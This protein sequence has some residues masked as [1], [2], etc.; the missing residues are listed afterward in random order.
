VRRGIAKLRTNFLIVAKLRRHD[1]T[2]GKFARNQDGS[3]QR[4]VVEHWP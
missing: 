3:H 2:A 1:R 4:L